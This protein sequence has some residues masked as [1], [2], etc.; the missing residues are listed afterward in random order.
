LGF[1][2]FIPGIPLGTF[3]LYSR[4]YLKTFFQ[5]MPPEIGF[6]IPVYFCFSRVSLTLNFTI[7]DIKSSGIGLLRGNCTEPFDPS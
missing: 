5:Y 2:D 6:E 7:L 1:N 4:Y 3:T